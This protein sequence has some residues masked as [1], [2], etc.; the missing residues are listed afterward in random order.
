[1]GLSLNQPL[2]LS[3]FANIFEPAELLHNL[4][5]ILHKNEHSNPQPHLPPFPFKQLQQ[6]HTP[7]PLE[8]SRSFSTQLH[9]PIECAVGAVGHINNHEQP[10]IVVETAQSV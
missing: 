7:F 10:F 9:L 6:R 1:M 4:R 5:F 3:F 8:R 2:N